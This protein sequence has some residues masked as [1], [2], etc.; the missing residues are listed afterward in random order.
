M[1][2]VDGGARLPEISIDE[3]NNAYTPSPSR[4]YVR[5]KKALKGNVAENIN[6]TANCM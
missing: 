2:T 4:R 5:D 3:K 1:S 6:Y